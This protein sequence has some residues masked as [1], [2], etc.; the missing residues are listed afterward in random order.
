[1]KKP[2]YYG[3]RDALTTITPG[4]VIGSG[5]QSNR[6]TRNRTNTL[7]TNTSTPAIID[8][9]NDDVVANNNDLN[10]N[11]NN[12][13]DD[14]A[15]DMNRN[16]TNMNSTLISYKTIP[17]ESDAYNN[18]QLWGHEW[19]QPDPEIDLLLEN[20][21]PTTVVTTTTVSDTRPDW[22]IEQQEQHLSP[23][24]RGKLLIDMSSSPP[25]LLK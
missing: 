17:L 8:L 5:Y 1:M 19:I 6:L 14:D 15:I 11:D 20:N 9:V 18:G 23:A 4:H 21:I 2:A 10:M 12:Q 24:Q 16:H 25:D 7:T 13:D 3:L 22:E